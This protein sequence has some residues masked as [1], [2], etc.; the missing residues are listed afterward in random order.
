MKAFCSWSGG[1]DSCLSCYEAMLQG[2]EVAYLLTMFSTTGK[3]THSHR[4]SKELILAQSHSVGIPGY[5]RGASWDSYEKK[6]KRALAFLKADG[7]QAGIF[8][9]LWVDEHRKWVERVCDESGITP[10]LPLWRMQGKDLLRRFIDTGFEAV[11]VAVKDGVLGDEWL[12]RTINEEFIDEMTGQVGDM[13]GEQGEYHTLV[14]DGPVF[15]KRIAIGDAKVITR[16]EISFLDILS[17]DL[18]GK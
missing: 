8:G 17:F 5:D 6:F 7:V 14:V 9:D 11:V 1:K 15:G 10:L 16:K 4:L 13:C 2:H 3:Y 18:E 12:G